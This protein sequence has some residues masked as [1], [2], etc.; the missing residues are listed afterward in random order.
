MKFLG[1][2]RPAPAVLSL[3]AGALI[4]AGGYTAYTS[5]ALSYLSDDSRACANCHVMREYYDSWQKA[6]HHARATCNGCHV[7]HPIVPKYISKA[8]NGYHHSRGFTLQDFHEPIRI[9]PANRAVLNANCLACHRDL[10]EGIA[11]HPAR[12][13]DDMDCARCHR[14]AGHGP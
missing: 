9:R 12:E 8:V 1:G 13:E 14:S 11:P 2:L 4:G 10:V 3:L 5:H 7:P 6:S